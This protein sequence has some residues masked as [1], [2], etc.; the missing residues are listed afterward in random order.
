MKA[1]A[2]EHTN[3]V[4]PQHLYCVFKILMHSISAQSNK[5]S[6]SRVIVI[7]PIDGLRGTSRPSRTLKEIPFLTQNVHLR[8]PLEQAAIIYSKSFN[9]TSL[10]HLIN[11]V[12]LVTSSGFRI[13][14]VM[15][16][17]NFITEALG[18]QSQHTRTKKD[19]QN[20]ETKFRLYTDKTEESCQIF[21]NQLE[22]L[23]KCGFNAS[24]PLVMIVH[25]WSV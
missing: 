23:D 12:S 25:G 13:H 16:V 18:S 15:T 21:L 8:P 6:I 20:S 14:P 24:L 3:I 1:L 17:T 19:Q 7:V 10:L 5:I 2:C 9:L 22:T 11:C 4:K